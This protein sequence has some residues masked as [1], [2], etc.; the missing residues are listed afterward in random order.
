MKRSWENH[1]K[2]INL[3]TKKKKKQLN[4]NSYIDGGSGTGTCMTNPS[5]GSQ[6]TCG[7]RTNIDYLYIKHQLR[8][9]N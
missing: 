3:I 1:L 9:Y 2:P 6:N 5:Y 8:P 4:H 7:D